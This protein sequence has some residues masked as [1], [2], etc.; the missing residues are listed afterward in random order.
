MRSPI[1][2]HEASSAVTQNPRGDADG[3]RVRGNISGHDGSGPDHGPA[4]DRH[5]EQDADGHA[6]V[7]VVLDNYPALYAALLRDEGLARRKNVLVGHDHRLRGDQHVV[8]DLH[9]GMAVD[10]ALAADVGARAEADIALL[11]L[12]LQVTAE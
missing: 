10:D 11:R 8:A 5:A 6:Q 4:P 7:D 12:I 9:T 2:V 3:H 1:K